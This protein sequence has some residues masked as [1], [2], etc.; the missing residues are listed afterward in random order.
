M[1]AAERVCARI[2]VYGRVQAVGFRPC[3]YR[4]ATELGIDG[5]VRNAGGHVVISASGCRQN[6]DEFVARLE[7][8]APPHARIDRVDVTPDPSTHLGAG[9]AIAGSSV[10]HSAGTVTPDL[11]TCQDCLRELWD[12]ADRRYR[13]P[14]VNC[15]NCGPRATIMT[16]LPYDRSRTS[17][18]GFWMCAR[19]TTEYHDPGNRRFHAEPIACPDCGPQ[20]A[21]DTA[22]GEDAL[23]AAI[24][25]V[26]D[27]GIVAVK[28]IGGY[29]L[30]CDATDDQA[31]RRLRRLKARQRKPFAVMTGS[32]AEARRLTPLT[33]PE[34]TVL[35]SAEAPIVLCAGTSARLAPSV[36]PDVAELGLF[37]PT[38]PLHHLLLAGLARPLVVTS[39]N[40]A[41]SPIVIDDLAATTELGPL[42]DGVL[43]HDR[44]IWSRCDDSVARVVSGRTTLLRRAR[45]YAP[46]F[47]RLPCATTA[48]VLAVGAQLKHTT[49]LA[50]ED[51]AYLGPYLGD[52]E[53]AETLAAF[54]RGVART[55]RLHQV[56][57]EYCACDLHPQYLST[58]FAERWPAGRRIPVQHHHAH[59][60]ATAAEHGVDGPFIGIAYDGLGLGED[61]TFWGGEILLATF[62]E[63]RRVGR[64]GLAPMPGGAA[65]IRRPARMA[66]GYLY[67]AETR[68]EPLHAAEAAV[69]LDRLDPIEVRGIRSAVGKRLNCPVTSSAGRLFDAVSALLGVC[70]SAS[71]EGEAAVLLEAAAAGHP[72]GKV[73]HWSLRRQED[74]WVFDPVPTL[75]HLLQAAIDAPP[76]AVAARFHTTMTEVT[77]ALAEQVASDSGVRTVC[78]GGGVFQNRRLLTQV[79][80]GLREVGLHGLVSAQVPVN[81]G[82]ISYGQAAVAAARLDRR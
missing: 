28:G 82:G 71:Y 63:H 43:R 14:F 44:P 74:L 75:R 69:L 1:E 52:L 41:G 59:V 4:L 80:D 5:F 53:N 70:D 16:S 42:V 8:T 36:A 17:M 22:R 76:G 13:Y 54:E 30:V 12:L 10:D 61:G 18:R 60:A 50:V 57:P 33:E 64:F 72:D 20:L 46:D 11:A 24:V 2:E 38:S 45:G 34:A 62:R 79:L 37:L 35:A 19:C 49:T 55:L 6:L 47:L 21:W 68:A 81:D 67:G 23:G 73:L 27:G 3:V 25:A 29:Q 40:V 9:F 32:V 78:L 48:P 26:A 31:V 65:A 66:L 39:G 15:T 58:R 7:R 56:S 77:V 51:R